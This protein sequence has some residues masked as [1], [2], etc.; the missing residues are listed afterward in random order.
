MTVYALE[1]RRF[2]AA[3]QKV[4][5]ELVGYFVNLEQQR[6]LWYFALAVNNDARARH[7][8]ASQAENLLATLAS[9]F[10]IRQNHIEAA[11]A[12]APSRSQAETGPQKIIPLRKNT[13]MANGFEDQLATFYELMHLKVLEFRQALALVLVLLENYPALKRAIR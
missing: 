6:Q 11:K 13:L 4:H 2:E 10:D 7:Y 3:K 5:Q 8:T 12:F 9:H 1:Q